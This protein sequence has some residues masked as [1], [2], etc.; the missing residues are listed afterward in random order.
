V[1]ELL[2][3]AA[4]SPDHKMLEP[5]RFIVL[6]EAALKRVSKQATA[7]GEIYGIAPEKVEKTAMVFERSPLCVAVVYS[8]K[9]GTPVPYEEQ[10][11]S[12]GAVCLALVNGAL[13]S[14]WGAGWITGWASFDAGF[15]A[16]AF[17]MAEDEYVAGFIHIGTESVTPGDR[18]R[19]SITAKTQWISE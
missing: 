9:H 7:W 15:C 18:K 2:T 13:A 14:G 12:A 10:V 4:R 1:N 19:P 3:I 6:K 17:G 8:P 11:L 16:Q 5:W